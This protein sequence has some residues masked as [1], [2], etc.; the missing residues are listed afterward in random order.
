[1]ATDTKISDKLYSQI[2]D[3]EYNGFFTPSAALASLSVLAS[4]LPESAALMA[5]ESS[6]IVENESWTTQ[7]SKIVASDLGQ[8]ISTPT[9]GPSSA[10]GSTNTASSSSGTSSSSG[11]AAAPTAGAGVMA[12]AAVAAAGVVGMALL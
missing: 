12:G 7:A 8:A 6:L 1:M 4:G 3:A 11:L 9:N 10:P 5:Y 2:E